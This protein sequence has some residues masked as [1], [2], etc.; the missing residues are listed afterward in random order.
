MIKRLML[1]SNLEVIKKLCILLI[2]KYR[3]GL[4]PRKGTR[5]PTYLFRVSSLHG[6]S[7]PTCSNFLWKMHPTQN[8]APR[9]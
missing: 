7:N 6:L 3:L 9:S 1:F 4:A 2:L 8:P 5:V